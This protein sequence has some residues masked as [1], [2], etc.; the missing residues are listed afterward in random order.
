MRGVVGTPAPGFVVV[1]SR[2]N[3]SRASV[4][5]LQGPP[6]VYLG[7]LIGLKGFG[8]S[9]RSFSYGLEA[10]RFAPP[11]RSKSKLCLMTSL[12]ILALLPCKLH[13]LLPCRSPLCIQPTMPPRRS[14]S[15]R[16]PKAEPGTKATPV[17]VDT[18]SDRLDHVVIMLILFSLRSVML[19]RRR[20]RSW[21]RSNSALTRR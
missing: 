2:D 10:K 12:R 8:C 21:P 18:V 1:C 4:F 13:R 11:S 20:L 14:T 19:T 3:G 7:N 5:A 16:T 15:S 17:V 9:I 6:W